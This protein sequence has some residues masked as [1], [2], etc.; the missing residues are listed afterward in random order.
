MGGDPGEVHAAAAV[1]DDDEDVEA[2]Q[3]HGVDVTEIQG[4]DRV[5]LG[6]QELASGRPGPSRREI[7]T[8]VLT[9]EFVG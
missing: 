7:E 2:A 3:D 8:G 9:K 1:L 5:G 6:G 4:Q